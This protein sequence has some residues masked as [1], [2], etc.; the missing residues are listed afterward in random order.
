MISSSYFFAQFSASG[1]VLNRFYL[2]DA[3]KGKKVYSF[4][5]KFLNSIY[6]LRFFCYIMF[7]KKR[8]FCPFD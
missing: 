3:Q 4:R 5:K 8:D 7:V 1:G 2:L 6:K